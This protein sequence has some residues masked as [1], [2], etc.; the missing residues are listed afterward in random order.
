MSAPT[1]SNIGP[2]LVCAAVPA[3]RDRT[4]DAPYE[5][6]SSLATASRASPIITDAGHAPAGT[7]QRGMRELAATLMEPCFTTS[8]PNTPTPSPTT[9]EMRISPEGLKLPPR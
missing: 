4:G 6:Q 5:F 8:E 2:L 7:P 1:V 9:V 3:P